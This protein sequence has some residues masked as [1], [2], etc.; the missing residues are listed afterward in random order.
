MSNQ[1]LKETTLFTSP[2]GQKTTTLEIRGN[3]L[4]LYTEDNEIYK[5]FRQWTQ[6][7][8]KTPYFWGEKVIAADLYFPLSTRNQLLRALTSSV[9][10]NGVSLK[11]KEFHQVKK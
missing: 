9:P 8:Y 2:R 1:H 4:A 10:K 7:L 6:L 3:R 5:R 11:A